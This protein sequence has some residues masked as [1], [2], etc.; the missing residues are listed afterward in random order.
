MYLEN[1]DMLYYGKSETFWRQ[2]CQTCERKMKIVAFKIV[3]LT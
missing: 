2:K 3:K 1:E